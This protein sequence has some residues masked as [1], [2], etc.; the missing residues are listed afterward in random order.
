MGTNQKILE[1]SL[2]LFNEK[3]F[4]EVGVR[5]I[6]RSMG[7]SPGNLS[8]HFPKKEDIFFELMRDYSKKNDLNYDHFFLGEPTLY[9]YLVL[10]RNMLS[11]QY[12]HRG[13]FQA[14]PYLFEEIYKK[15]RLDYA[16]TYQRRE[17]S[18]RKILDRLNE[19]NQIK[20]GENDVEFLL[21]FLT[22][23]GRFSIHEAFLVNNN[24]EERDVLFHYLSML[25][26]QMML[27]ATEKG[28][29]SIEE[30]RKEFL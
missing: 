28:K 24:R 16:Q 1:A 25:A 22:L 5:E 11:S 30:F 17:Q 27:F 20:V 15:G 23:F 26:H 6:A 8:Y 3:G 21:S 12:Q 2:K 9:R 4:S 7:I 10:A 14:V 13:L 29:L 19:A 18:V